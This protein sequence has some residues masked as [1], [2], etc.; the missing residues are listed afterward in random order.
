MDKSNKKA[1]KCVFVGYADHHTP[2]TYRMYKPNTRT[3]ILSRDV[4]WHD[5]VS[6]NPKSSLPL[7]QGEQETLRNSYPGMNPRN[8]TTH[9]N[10][11]DSMLATALNEHFG[12][13]REKDNTNNQRTNI[14]RQQGKSTKPTAR[15]AMTT[16]MAM[17]PGGSNHIEED[18][19]TPVVDRYPIGTTVM[20]FFKNHGYFSGKVTHCSNHGKHYRV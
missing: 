19:A 5:W 20:K 4:K 12:S 1:E 3:I 7:Y 10:P 14:T 15:K 16:A 11:S 13:G 9:T 18:Q 6:Y 2:D 8:V 17:K